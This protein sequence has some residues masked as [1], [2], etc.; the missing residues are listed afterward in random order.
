MPATFTFDPR[1]VFW[2]LLAVEAIGLT[3]A[4]LVRLSAGCRGHVS[5]QWLFFACLS[6]VGCGSVVAM[7]ISPVCW[8][9]SAVTLAMMIVAVVW[10]RS[11]NT[12]GELA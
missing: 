5:C 12:R 2:I 4:S 6:L 3:S 9:L 8:L 10:D 11:Q 7:L 1:I